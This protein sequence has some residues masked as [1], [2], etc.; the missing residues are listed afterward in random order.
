VT[1]ERARRRGA[2]IRAACAAG[3]MA[4]VAAAT[5]GS[6][7]GPFVF[8]DHPSIVNNAAL[9]QIWPPRWLHAEDSDP[10]AGR[11]LVAF[12]MALGRALHGPEPIGFRAVNIGLHVLNALLLMGIVR[13]LLERWDALGLGAEGASWAAGATALVWA[14]HPLH[15]EVIGY[16]SQRTELMAASCYLGAFACALRGFDAAPG[17]GRRRWFAAAAG[18]ALAG[19]LC[20]EV[21]V[22]LP[23]VVWCADR[24]FVSGSFG[25]AFRRHRGLYAGLLL[26]WLPVA[27]VTFGGVR[28]GSVGF[29]H[30]ISALDS[31]RTQSLAIAEYL[32]LSVFPDRLRLSY[33]LRPVR[34]W[35]EVG[36]AAMLVVGLFLATLLACWR[37][38][39]PG[40]AGAWFFLILGPSSSF[41]PIVT[42][43]AALRRMYLPVAAVVALL[44]V[45]AFAIDARLAQRDAVRGRRSAALALV[46]ILGLG[47]PLGWRS[48][49]R[50]EDYRSR[51]A[52]WSEDVRQDPHNPIALFN[53]AM[54]H[55]DAGGRGEAVAVLEGAWRALSGFDPDA[56][57]IIL[58]TTHLGQM[59]RAYTAAGQPAAGLPFF[60]ELAAMHPDTFT[61]QW[62][63]GRLCLL[64]GQ[65]DE[66][67][68]PLRRA[69]ELEPELV[70]A[71]SALAEA[72]ARTDQR[73]EAAAELDRAIALAVGEEADRLRARRA[74]LGPP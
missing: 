64:A 59:V 21:I 1:M 13:R 65:P 11:P 32:R 28:S 42:E 17:S 74:Q 37:R 12:S 5:G 47:G 48:R 60:R 9:E 33:P 29:G 15:T 8:D 73:A 35:S 14:V 53:L 31:I 23:L 19:G 41:V 45:G 62:N 10:L 54:A 57:A 18:A 52:L 7:A 69:V 3:I 4:A 56:R 43:V 27:V 50:L 49:D 38:P 39:R 25:A 66:A 51:V 30:G 22:T 26:A 71:R 34:V 36:P 70:L 40:F 68:G 6:L 61:I 55:L 16:I 44:V 72:L 46:L 2:W 20:K 63:Y 58:G 67:L 24:A